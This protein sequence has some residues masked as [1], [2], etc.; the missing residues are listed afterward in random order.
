MVRSGCHSLPVE[1]RRAEAGR[2]AGADSAR[3]Q[4]DFRVPCHRAPGFVDPAADAGGEAGRRKLRECELG[5]KRLANLAT[6][7]DPTAANRGCLGR[8]IDA[9]RLRSP[10]AYARHWTTLD[11][12]TRSSRWSWNVTRW[13][14]GCG[15]SPRLGGADH[16]RVP[17]HDAGT[18][19]GDI[20]MAWTWRQLHDTL[21]ERD[22]LDAHEL[23]RQID[24]QRE[25]LRQVT[26]EL[27]DARAWGRQLERLQGNQS[28]RQALVGWLDTTR[29]L[30]STRQ[31][32]RRQDLLSAARKLDEAVCRGGAGL[33]H[34]RF[35]SWPRASIPVPRAS[36]S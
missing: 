25:R 10:Q 34:A 3:G 20:A 9:V 26:E 11:A 13:L 21:V 17:P 12:C 5:F 23:Q 24:H 36:T 14:E 22:R 1:V 15:L 31:L 33:D 7:V 32:D 29:R 8:I 35:R 2:A 28:I 16:S 19:P 6:Q 27:I 18:I 30:V 4:C